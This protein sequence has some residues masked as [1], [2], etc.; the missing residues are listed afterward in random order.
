MNR[1]QIIRAWKDP[2]F[3]ATLTKEQLAELPPTPIGTFELTEEDLRQAAGASGTGGPQPGDCAYTS[4][5]C[6]RWCDL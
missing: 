2:S 4:P 5:T 3:R 1:E 6:D